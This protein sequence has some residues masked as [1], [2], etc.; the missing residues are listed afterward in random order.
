MKTNDTRHFRKHHVCALH[1]QKHTLE[2][3]FKKIQKYK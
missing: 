3:A 2:K 1:E